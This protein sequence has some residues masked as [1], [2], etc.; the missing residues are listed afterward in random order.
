MRNVLRI[1]PILL[2]L[3]SAAFAG[4]SVST[5]TSGA[6]SASPVHVVANASSSNPVTAMAVYFDNVLKYKVSSAKV[7]TYIS[8]SAGSHYVVVQAWDSTG[9]VSKTALNIKVSTTTSSDTGSAIPS[10]AKYYSN[11]DQMTGWDS[12]DNCAGR[13]GAG[14]DASYSYAINQASPSMDGK[15]AVFFLG[16]TAPYSAALWWKQLG[17]NSSVGHFVYDLY[18]YMKN[19]GASQALE[20]DVNQ[21]QNGKKWIFGT[22]CDY[23]DHKD[24]DVWDTKNGAW[25]KT[26]IPCTQPAAYTWNHLVL[27]FQRTS[28]GMAQFISVTLNGKKNYINKSFYPKAANAYE[29]NTAFQMDGNGTMTDYST[30]LDK[31]Q[32]VA[33]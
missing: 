26:G 28:G 6:T 20:F 21:S 8:T 31:V 22:Q 32:L 2:A 17:G 27:E 25:I 14:P 33:W 30:W 5:P 29:L 7:D 10:T 24:W 16:G 9:Y 19:P 13:G 15:S 11:I 18:F 1:A 12:C 23:K 3:A 4:V